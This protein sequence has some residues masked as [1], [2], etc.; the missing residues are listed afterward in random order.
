MTG[1]C[2][3]N[4][5]ACFGSCPTIY[6]VTDGDTLLQAEGFS[7]SIAPVLEAADIDHLYRTGPRR[8]DVRLE[9][10]N[11][12]LET[13][14]IRYAHLRAVPLRGAQRA[15]QGL[16]GGFWYVG[17][18]VAPTRCT[19]HDG[20]CL[21]ALAAFDGVERT[22]RTD[23]TDLGAREVVTLTFA[24]PA[25]GRGLVVAS[26]QSLVSTY[27]FYQAL[28]YLGTS[29]GEWLAA[30]SRGDPA[31]LAAAHR[32][33]DALGGIDVDVARPDGRWQRIGSISEYG[34]LAADVRVL[35]LPDLPGPVQL[36]LVMAQGAWRL[37]WAALA[38]LEGAATPER[39]RP[40]MVWRDGRP[41]ARALARLTDTTTA[42]VTLPGD[43]YVI[44]YALPATAYR[45][46]LFL[47]TRGYYLEWMR[48]EWLA[49]EDPV[50]AAQLFTDP[51][52]LLRRVAPAFKRVETGMDSLFWR[53]A[54]AR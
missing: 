23:S 7:S 20:D 50:L 45:H 31:V 26:R 22:S 49:E 15:V 12:A 51:R 48:R 2:A 47:E 38:T 53:S 24:G 17:P 14:V 42:L 41:D 52:G 11:E 4:P 27:L 46:E 25:V 54:Y 16:D 8:G 40:A 1:Y 44:G 36:R 3:A 37:D 30:L 33:R 43:R 6:T 29:A 32:S 19:G 28:S 10:V 9:L 35:P 18:P 5:K 34:P 13:H 21:T 39:V